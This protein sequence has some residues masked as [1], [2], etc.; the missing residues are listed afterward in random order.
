MLMKNS[1]AGKRNRKKTVILALIFSLIFSTLAYGAP[2][3]QAQADMKLFT[4]Y[5][6]STIMVD[7]DAFMTTVKGADAASLQPTFESKRA[8]YRENQTVVFYK[9]ASMKKD[10]KHK[11]SKTY[12]T[13]YSVVYYQAEV[14]TIN[15]TSL[16]LTKVAGGSYVKT[17]KGKQYVTND[18]A[19][20]GET[21]SW[22]DTPEGFRQA[23]EEYVRSAVG[24]EYTSSDNPT[25]R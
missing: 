5:L 13:P 25:E 12:G 8:Y 4:K 20:S 9:I 2:T 10:T 23:F 24:G 1:V 3:K 15:M 11:V 16:R 18:L 19:Y 22:S 21:V 7:F 14:D 17:I 6:D